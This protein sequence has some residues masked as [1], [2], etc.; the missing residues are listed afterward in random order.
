MMEAAALWRE[1]RIVTTPRYGRAE[2][3][4]PIAARSFGA[5]QP[6]FAHRWQPLNP[7]RLLR[8]NPKPLAKCL[9]KLSPGLGPSVRQP[10]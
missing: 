3:D 9:S 8:S 2:I 5:A 1:I 4:K 6:G 7:G 10:G